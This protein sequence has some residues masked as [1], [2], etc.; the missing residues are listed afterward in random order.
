MDKER[1]RKVRS[2]WSDL[3]KG[4]G[5]WASLSASV[6]YHSSFRSISNSSNTSSTV[7]R[8]GIPAQS[9]G[10]K[11][12]V[13]SDLHL[14]QKQKHQTEQQ[15]KYQLQSCNLP[16]SLHFQQDASSYKT[17]NH[18]R[19]KCSN[20]TENSMTSSQ[21]PISDP[22]P[23]IQTLTCLHDHQTHSGYISTN[24]QGSFGCDSVP[25]NQ[26]FGRMNND[27]DQFDT[28]QKALHS[29]YTHNLPQRPS[30]SPSFA[31]NILVSP[32]PEAAF[33]HNKSPISFHVEASSSIPATKISNH[34]S[35]YAT[36]N[37]YETIT[38]D[39][40]KI[41][42]DTHN[43]YPTKSALKN[44]SPIQEE[45]AQ[46][47]FTHKNNTSFFRKGSLNRLLNSKTN[48][49][50]L[51][52]TYEKQSKKKVSFV[53]GAPDIIEYET[54][55]SET[56]FVTSSFN[57]TEKFHS[58]QG[59][60]F[61]SIDSDGYNTKVDEKQLE[62][63][64]LPFLQVNE[65]DSTL[66]A[67]ITEP[68]E[69]I[70]STLLSIT[71][72]STAQ[73]LSDNDLNRDRYSCRKNTQA[74]VQSGATSLE[75]HPRPLPK[76]PKSLTH[77]RNPDKHLDRQQFSDKSIGLLSSTEPKIKSE[78]ADENLFTEKFQEKFQTQEQINKIPELSN[79]NL[80]EPKNE[81]EDIIRNTSSV[82]VKTDS[83]DIVLTKSNSQDGSLFFMI[84]DSHN[85][86]IQKDIKNG[87]NEGT[88]TN[89]KVEHSKQVLGQQEA[90]VKDNWIPQFFDGMYLE[91]HEK[92]MYEKKQKTQD[93]NQ[94][95]L[96]SS[97]SNQTQ[98][99]KNLQTKDSESENNFL[100]DSQISTTKTETIKIGYEHVA[101][102]KQNDRHLE[103]FPVK[104][105]SVQTTFQ[106]EGIFQ[107]H[108][109]H[110][111]VEQKP[112]LVN[113][114]QS[115]AET[116]LKISTVKSQKVFGNSQQT[117]FTQ[118]DRMLQKG[119][120]GNSES[121]QMDLSSV[122]LHKPN[123][124]SNQIS[125]S[126]KHSEAGNN[127]EPKTQPITT[128][129][130]NNKNQY[131]TNNRNRLS[132]LENHGNI[133][134]SRTI[135]FV[136]MSTPLHDR[137]EDITTV[138]KS[139]TGKQTSTP[140]WNIRST[141]KDVKSL[142]KTTSKENVHYSIPENTHKLTQV[143]K[144]SLR[145]RN[146]SDFSIGKTCNSLE[147]G[148][149]GSWYN[150]HA[151][152]ESSST[153]ALYSDQFR[154][155]S[156]EEFHSVD[157]S[158]PREPDISSP[159][160]ALSSFL[161][162]FEQRPL[163]GSLRVSPNMLGPAQSASDGLIGYQKLD[164]GST[165]LCPVSQL[166]ED[167]IFAHERLEWVPNLT[168]TTYMDRYGLN[169]NQFINKGSNKKQNNNR[170]YEH[171]N[172]YADQ[173][174]ANKNA[175]MQPN[176]AQEKADDI[177]NARN[178]NKPMV[179]T[180]RA[181]KIGQ[182][183]PAVEHVNNGPVFKL[184]SRPCFKYEQSSLH[185]YNNSDFLNIDSNQ[186]HFRNSLTQHHHKSVSIQPVDPLIKQEDPEELVNRTTNSK[187]IVPLKA[188]AHA[189]TNIGSLKAFVPATIRI[190]QEMNSTINTPPERTIPRFETHADACLFKERQR[191]TST[192]EN[193][194]R[195]SS[196][197]FETTFTRN[198]E[199]P[200]K[201][202]EQ[203]YIDGVCIRPRV[204]SNISS[205]HNSQILMH[206]TSLNDLLPNDYYY[207]TDNSNPIT[208]R[209]SQKTEKVNSSPDP[210]S[211]STQ[212]SKTPFTQGGITKPV[213]LSSAVFQEAQ[214]RYRR[215]RDTTPRDLRD[216]SSPLLQL[217]PV[218]PLDTPN[219]STLN[220]VTMLDADS[221]G[222]YQQEPPSQ[223]LNQEQPVCEEREKYTQIKRNQVLDG[224]DDSHT[225]HELLYQNTAALT[226]DFNTKKEQT[227]KN[228]TV[229]GEQVDIQLTNPSHHI[230][231]ESN[232]KDPNPQ[233]RP[234]LSSQSSDF[235]SKTDDTHVHYEYP[236]VFKREIS[237]VGEFGF[238]NADAY[239]YEHGNQAEVCENDNGNSDSD[240]EENYLENFEVK[241]E[242][243]DNDNDAGSNAE[244][245]REEQYDTISS[246]IVARG[247]KMKARP[248]LIPRDVSV[249]RLIELNHQTAHTLSLA[250]SPD[251]H[252]GLEVSRHTPEP[253]TT[254]DHDIYE[255][256]SVPTTN[257]PGRGKL[258]T[259]N[260]NPN[261]IY[262]H[263]SLTSKNE[264]V[265][266]SITD[267]TYKSNEPKPNSLMTTTY[268][269][270]S[271]S[272]VQDHSKDGFLPSISQPLLD[273]DV[274]SS[275]SESLLDDLDKEFDRMFHESVCLYLLINLV[276]YG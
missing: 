46:K 31:Q 71:Q 75:S 274:S 93:T 55:T 219:P 193:Q 143:S 74:R 128:P 134:T 260:T 145:N 21:R 184:Y 164:N 273:F 150:V 85:G 270:S 22:E 142:L 124:N 109:L 174:F 129:I 175:H 79:K 228:P 11:K 258:P 265:G 248:S 42:D 50:T 3:E 92:V 83:K 156:F 133:P 215:S 135:P 232:K 255:P 2:F 89:K 181:T 1:S 243:E 29:K 162:S 239:D 139:L 132:L 52:P 48:M 179:Q 199:E 191:Q 131:A 4:S 73:I 118:C 170:D 82:K 205:H 15:S 8:F 257:G 99:P 56:P 112:I 158:H 136:S 47:A 98:S 16:D 183:V 204:V 172:K 168:S 146:N 256:V 88:K 252:P 271:T 159:T 84:S 91:S 72:D 36:S 178:K 17:D 157:F 206:R 147:P 81:H 234:R 67:P 240:E 108:P 95:C 227:V 161:P 247:T 267:S 238:K 13:Q 229:D 51:L 272:N 38:P 54:T 49:L 23:Y 196:L 231:Q 6:T 235:N 194:R 241:R 261:N 173:S 27:L 264:N 144:K 230:V 180:T 45:S 63:Q 20:S 160:D 220:K 103:D 87:Q 65:D 246:T 176:K 222:I 10:Q 210:S 140:L 262:G 242:F 151:E 141:D 190:K 70:G 111:L 115:L 33:N 64:M 212:H 37:K 224:I 5:N 226:Q 12:F 116:P 117:R 237:P 14:R 105:E 106:P 39:T 253:S 166:P 223:E 127:I 186:E 41:V 123:I 216:Y 209:D 154:P 32:K 9:I 102:R 69:R 77:L 163:S 119:S 185:T 30:C 236:P 34:Q 198:E 43:T 250:P 165:N 97:K 211:S 249:S 177:P 254:D 202:R 244:N 60:I 245:D 214:E 207:H 24:S 80:V 126:K 221:L 137:N 233:P 58:D 62:F 125:A 182:D 268:S 107:D 200:T 192:S 218:V 201:N 76:A 259:D 189:T 114:S 113:Q 208:D 225:N 276:Y 53:R 104:K 167:V 155:I 25:L 61:D 66:N 169:G 171:H 203:K 149:Y 251:P 138:V 90:N 35:I 130:F 217:A 148:L 266:L 59:L 68:P 78:T 18:P 187:S 40:T 110:S 197:A 152:V 7:S 57:D 100:T 101:K 275:A 269:P 153:P 96:N 44:S 94:N 120:K 121:N 213:L 86:I 122:S 26:N 195:P 188:A 28:R 19:K 263:Y